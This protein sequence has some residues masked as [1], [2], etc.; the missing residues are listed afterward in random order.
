LPISSAEI[1]GREAP[2]VNIALQRCAVIKL[3]HCKT[4]K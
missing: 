2:A 1:V 3:G 4:I